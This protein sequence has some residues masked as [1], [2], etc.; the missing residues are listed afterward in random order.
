MIWFKRLLVWHFERFK[1]RRILAIISRTSKQRNSSS[2]PNSSNWNLTPSSKRRPGAKIS[3][4]RLCQLVSRVWCHN[5]IP[6]SLKTANSLYLAEFDRTHS[7]TR[8]SRRQLEY[9]RVGAPLQEEPAP[10][11]QQQRKQLAAPNFNLRGSSRSI[12]FVGQLGVQLQLAA[13]SS[14]VPNGSAKKGSLARFG[15][16]RASK[17]ARAN[18]ERATLLRQP[19]DELHKWSGVFFHWNHA[20]SV[21]NACRTAWHL[22]AT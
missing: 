10:M 11:W 6:L 2:S 1:K 8:F 13:S 5:S 15:L 20:T 9:S 18:Q 17:V 12:R 16:T 14:R 3:S 4:V 19:T 21:G 7:R 22:E